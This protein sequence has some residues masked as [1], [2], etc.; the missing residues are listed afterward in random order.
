M[1][2]SKTSVI[3][4]SIIRGTRLS[5]VFDAK[6]YYA[7][8]IWDTVRLLLSVELDYPRFWGQILVRPSYM[9]YS[10]TSVI[11]ASIVRGNSIIRSF[12]G[13]I[14]VRPSYMKYSQTSVIRGFWGQILVSPSYMKYSQTSVIRGTRL[15]AVFEAKS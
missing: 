1:K 5:A 3:R 14:L 11:R 10:K 8:V 6:F 12:W 4:A 15:S 9:K 2:Y 7:Q 13:Q